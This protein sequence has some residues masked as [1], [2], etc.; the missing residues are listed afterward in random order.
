MRA[1]TVMRSG[2]HTGAPDARPVVEG[3]QIDP[4]RVSLDRCRLELGSDADDAPRD[5]A[6]AAPGLP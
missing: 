4:F 3:K 1:T 2:A 5:P 6:A